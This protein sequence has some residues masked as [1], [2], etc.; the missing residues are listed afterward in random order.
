MPESLLNMREIMNRRMTLRRGAMLLL[1]ACAIGP[2]TACDAV[3]RLLEVNNPEAIREREINDP[4][5]V[6]V[7]VNSVIGQ[8]ANT[9]DDPFLWV[10][11][12]ATDEVVTGINWEDYARVNQRII[13]YNEGPADE[14]F[15]EL[16]EAR[17]MADTVSSM[18]RN[19]L[20]DPDSDRR[21][22]LTLA[23]SGYSYILLGDAMCEATINVGATRYTPIQLYE[24]AVPRLE[25]ALAIAQRAGDEAL[26]NLARVGL[27]RVHL[28]LGNNAEVMEHAAQVPLSFRWWVEYS[29]ANPDVYFELYG[30]THGTNHTLGVH[31]NF[32]IY[33]NFRDQN[34][35]N[36][37]DPRIQHTPRWTTGHNA[38]T[39]LYKP[40][41]PLL[42]SGYT[43]N[44]VAE[45]CANVTPAQCTDAYIEGTGRLSLPQRE[46]DVAL[47]SGIEA[48]HHYYEAAGASGSGP[49]GTTL[50]FIN[51]RRAVGNQAPVTLSGAALT[52]ELRE[53]RRR[54]LYLAGFRLGDLRRWARQ[55]EDRF[56]AGTHPNTQWGDYGPD[57]CFPIPREEF[58]G[59]P[60]L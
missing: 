19:L 5:L 7:L 48:M 41:Q 49:L 22:A 47:A 26:V 42:F 33:G 55:G 29:D 52:A 38:L 10:G 40:F 60:N 9:Y 43:G 51:S 44:T 20:D 3:D 23:Y 37:T 50:Q 39:P 18:L 4:R 2:L 57:T 59:N 54:D 30:Q 45:I 56:P 12:M 31:P 46:T 17:V 15:S 13:R 21:L 25:E 8:L 53:Q 28:N 14:M 36:Q 11:T 27:A 34:V 32:F 24:M 6:N 58:T 1:T 35:I 16:S